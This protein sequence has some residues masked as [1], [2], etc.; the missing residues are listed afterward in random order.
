[1][2]GQ[3]EKKNISAATGV[4]LPFRSQLLCNNIFLFFFWVVP[5]LPPLS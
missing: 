4:M 1:M 2:R 5:K 3:Q